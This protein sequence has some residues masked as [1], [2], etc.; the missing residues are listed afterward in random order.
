M[1]KLFYEKFIT[2]Y[3]S[4]RIINAEKQKLSKINII[5]NIMQHQNKMPDYLR[6]GIRLFSIL[7]FFQLIV[8][9]KIY[10]A[11][12]I[13]ELLDKSRKSKI[14]Y[15]R[16]LIRLH[17]SLFELANNNR[18]KIRDSKSSRK[19]IR[20][21][22]FDFVVIG[23]GPG[24]ATVAKEL[25]KAGFKTIII[26]TGCSFRNESIKSFSYQEILNKYKNGGITATFGN[27]NI[28]YA[29][30]STLGG[31]SEINSG[32]YHR[33]PAEILTSWKNKF[34][35]DVTDK[36]E[37]DDYYRIIEKNLCVSYSPN[38]LIPKASLKLKLGAK[39][40]GWI[41]EEA[42]RWV[43]YENTSKPYGQKMTMSQTYLDK[44]IKYGGICSELTKAKLI[45]K[46]GENW[47]I[48]FSTKQG[49]DNVITKN[50]VLSAGAIN[51]PHILQN[52][53]LSKIA[54]KRLEMHPTIK[55]VALFDEEIN[56]KNMGVP[57][58][59]VKEFSPH[60]TLGC[61]ISSKPYLRIAMLDHFKKLEIIEEKWK[62]MAIYYA[63]IIPQGIGSVRGIPYFNDPL[64]Y[65]HLTKIDT[66]NLAIGL[67]NFVRY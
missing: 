4:S 49:N 36:T 24:G 19:N 40:L 25:Q 33:I 10:Y 12:T 41:V 61:S 5:N 53:K 47:R 11:Q 14:N 7:Y 57:A 42:P 28:A 46:N 43:N 67:K 30:G 59:Q 23:S 31:G 1:I 52:S 8:L 29:E 3:V 44:F 58:H 21:E 34:K 20:R 62:F 22:I 64:V 26:E 54:G 15:L 37:F 18:K 17:D 6:A 45:T 16:K 39:N 9:K 50:V 51:T 38:A 35:F 13:T 55:V 27:S 32:F 65:Y 48:D 66:Q 2:M 60:I 63:A 56:T